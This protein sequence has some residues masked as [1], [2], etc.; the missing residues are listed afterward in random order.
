MKY[1]FYDGG[2]LGFPIGK[3]LA[4]FDLHSTPMLPTKFQVNLIDLSVKEKKQKIR[5][6]IGKVLSI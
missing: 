4:T 6:P 5:F 2:L 1:R 3:V